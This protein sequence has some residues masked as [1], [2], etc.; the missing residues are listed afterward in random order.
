[1]ALVRFALKNPYLVLV[2]VVATVALGLIAYFRLPKDLLPLFKTPAV[3]ILT[4]YPGMPAEVVEKDI[5]SR[6]ERW[7]G[8]SN[9]IVRQESRSM[10]GVSIVKDYFRSDIDQNTALSQVTSLAMSDLYYLPPGTI[11]PMVM[12]FDPTATVPLVLLSISSPEYDE[13]KLYDIAYFDLR[14]RLQGIKGVI[15]PAVYGGRLRRIL[16]YA[17]PEKLKQYN[18]SLVD[19]ARTLKDFNTLIPAGNVKIGHTD[20]Q[21][22]SNG[23]VETVDEMNQFPVRSSLQGKEILISD[24]GRT[25]DSA[26]IQS[27]VVRVNG[28]R[29]VYI[30]VY[31]QPGA[32]TVAVVDAIRNSI[33]GILERLPKGISIDL[34]AD[35]S[36]YVRNAIRNLSL[37]A[38]EGALLAVLTIWLFLGSLRT[39]LVASISIPISIFVAFIGFL[40]TGDSL[41]AMTLGGL[42]LVVGRLVDDS[43]VVTENIERHHHLGK[44][45]ETASLGGA[46]E[47]M[48]PVLAATITTVIVFVPVFFLEGISA[49]LFAPLARSVAFSIGASFLAAMT[50]IPLL[51]RRAKKE[52]RSTT[53]QKGFVRFE[54]A[55]GRIL[56]MVLKRK[57]WVFA[58][59]LILGVGASLL[60][61]QVG[62]DLFPEQDVGHLTVKLRL[63]SGTRIEDTEREVSDIEK[64]IQN[65]IPKDEIRTLIAN[66]G[67]LYDWPAAYTPNAG[68]QDAFLEIQLNPHRH[69]SSQ[70]YANRLRTALEA[71]RAPPE[72]NT[73]SVA[74]STPEI[75][76]VIDTGG[77]LTAALTF[78]LPAPI[79]IQISGN[80]LKIA[81]R[82]AREVVGKLKSITG[83]VDLRVQQRQ[84]YPQLTVQVDRRKAASM[85]LTTVDVV[86]NV[87]AATNSSVS[88]DPA[89][90]IDPKNGNHYFAGVQYREKDLADEKALQEIRI[91]GKGQ[92]RAVPLRELATFGTRTAPTEINHLNIGRV[93]DVFANVSG[94]DLGS[95]SRAIENRLKDV[96][97]PTG[98]QIG[99]RGEMSNF[100]ES[101]ENLSF[102]FLLAVFLLYLVL[103]AQFRSLTDPLI[104]LI[105]VP[106][107]LIGV[108]TALWLT[109][110]TFN[111]QSFLGTIFMVGIVVSNS[112]LIVEFVNRS[113][114]QGRASV[115]DAIIEGSTIRLRPILMT[116]IAAIL[117][118][119]PMAIGFGEGSEANV[120]LAR[121]VIGGLTVST[122]LSLFVVPCLYC[123]FYARSGRF[124]DSS[125]S[126]G[127]IF[128]AC[129]LGAGA[130]FPRKSLAD[131]AR[132][133]ALDEALSYAKAHHPTLKAAEARIAGQSAGI[134]S[135]R[136]GYFPKLQG[137]GVLSNGMSGSTSGLGQPALS[138]SSFRKGYGV[139]LDLEATVYDFGRTANQVAAEESRLDELKEN[140]HVTRASL[141]MSVKQVYFECQRQVHYKATYVAALNDLE[142]LV[143]EVRQYVKSGQRSPVDLSL[144]EVALQEMS[145][146][147]IGAEQSEISSVDRLNFLMGAPAEERYSCMD[148]DPLR[149]PEELPP[150]E[151]LLEEAKRARPE[152]RRVFASKQRAVHE[153]DAARSQYFPKIVALASVGHL[154]DTNLLPSK[155][156]VIGLGVKIPL[157]DGFKTP[158]EVE[159]AASEIDR[160]GYEEEQVGREVA[161]EIGQAL[162]NYRRM[163]LLTPVIAQRRK[164]ASHALKLARERYMTRSGI[165]SEWDQ[166]YRA[167]LQS[168]LAYWNL[169][170]EHRLVAS[171]LNFAAGRE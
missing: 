20:Y 69:A 140:K 43:I 144:I 53:F 97:L 6:L 13:T 4:L 2:S 95:V 65:V 161:A 133:I 68:P 89:F 150:N 29:Q 62:Q 18:L 22:V 66:L 130:L 7:T 116:S 10:V 44:D 24:I 154:Q 26:Q 92:D 119:L 171:E 72:T 169:E 11:P 71:R 123:S 101:F 103:V 165:L 143:R 50:V 152:L 139:S 60:Y 74:D 148:D 47:V 159:K 39:A 3:Q 135:A 63:P 28:K 163:Q 102:G 164:T 132:P 128:L 105:T 85:G 117:G 126:K 79:D 73:R 118:L 122:F 37:E 56:P 46:G 124:R 27:N 51:L 41:N 149:S 127:V 23:M 86:K 45:A 84:D 136:A 9:G 94:R 64:E 8:Q 17:D 147:R 96:E 58:A 162:N 137:S 120:P 114:E 129:L 77:I 108:V 55:Y 76:V 110:S 151:K 59:C 98:Y 156:Y 104:I 33:K 153:K 30:P 80:D 121:A 146:N 155:D 170:Y 112:I 160:L 125:V 109:G 61:T 49:F 31:R 12:P 34:V 32:N 141:L 54:R 83:L 82:I 88:F 157:F 57:G 35:Q 21:I 99:L 25:E 166:A 19:V 16:T 48:G 36:E 145:A 75:D 87:V 138:N 70:E 52:Q 168:E 131:N 111:I 142:A 5:T 100:R 90:W 1:M 40:I 81:D 93:V 134:T 15:A 167:W 107:G 113:L 78:G 42:S 38:I 67:V 115:H 91:T 14:N 158:A 106:L